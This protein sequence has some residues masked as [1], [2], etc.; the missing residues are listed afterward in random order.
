MISFKFHR[1]LFSIS[2][3]SLV[4]NYSLNA[5]NPDIEPVINSN[6]SK[7]VVETLKL[8]DY[9]SYVTQVCTDV[10]KILLKESLKLDLVGNFIV[11]GDLHG[12][13]ISFGICLTRILH[14]LKNGMSALF[15]GDYV[16]RGSNGVEVITKVFELKILYPNN[17]FILRGNHEDVRQNI[18]GGFQE[19][20]RIKF[21]ETLE[22]QNSV[23][24]VISDVWD[25]LPI[26][27]VINKEFFC[28]HGGI[29][30]VFE[31]YD[32]VGKHLF[33]D[34]LE[35]A[36]KPLQLAK[37]STL[38]IRSV[39]EMLWND[40]SLY[41]VNSF[42]KRGGDSLEIGYCLKYD[43]C[44]SAKVNYIVR[45]HQVL[46]IFPF[47]DNGKIINVFSCLYHGKCKEEDE[48]CNILIINKPT[49]ENLKNTITVEKMS[50]LAKRYSHE[51][52]NNLLILFGKDVLK[53]FL[54]ST[55]YSDCNI[56]KNINNEN[57]SSQT[58]LS[59]VA[60]FVR[61]LRDALND[62]QT[63]NP[64]E[65]NEIEQQYVENMKKTALINYQLIENAYNKNNY[66]EVNKDKNLFILFEQEKEI[67]ETPLFQ[68]LNED[69][70]IRLRIYFLIASND[71]QKRC[72]MSYPIFQNYSYQNVKAEFDKID[73]DNQLELMM[74]FI[75]SF[76]ISNVHLLSLDY[77]SLLFD[78]KTG[79]PTQVFSDFLVGYSNKKNVYS[80][81]MMWYI[82]ELSYA[83]RK[84]I[85]IDD[86]LFLKFC[87]PFFD[88]EGADL[89]ANIPFL[90]DNVFKTNLIYEYGNAL[91]N[92]HYKSDDDRKEG[93]TKAA[94]VLSILTDLKQDLF[95]YLTYN[96]AVCLLK[97]T[98]D[99]HSYKSEVVENEESLIEK[100]I[101]LWKSLIS[102]KNEGLEEIFQEDNSGTYL[103]R[104]LP[105][106][107]KI[108]IRYAMLDEYSNEYS[109]PFVF[110]LL[111]EKDS[112]GKTFMS[113]LNM[114]HK[115][116]VINN[117]AEYAFFHPLDERNRT[118]LE[119]I[120]SLLGFTTSYNDFNGDKEKEWGEN[121]IFLMGILYES[122]PKNQK[123][124]IN[125]RIVTYGNILFDQKWE[126]KDIFLKMEK[127]I[128]A[129]GLYYY[130]MALYQ[131]GYKDTALDKFQKIASNYGTDF[132]NYEQ[133]QE[134]NK[135]YS[136]RNLL[137]DFS[138]FSK[139]V[140]HKGIS[141]L[142]NAVDFKAM[143]PS[144]DTVFSSSLR[145]PTSSET[146]FNS[147]AENN[148]D[149]DNCDDGEPA[150]TNSP[151]ISETPFAFFP[152]K[153]S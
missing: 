35:K 91:Y 129:Q 141:P 39:N 57:I 71:K 49:D 144:D 108:G 93:L 2:L 127:N 51:I 19:E 102:R 30:I 107:A 1:V 119:V 132:L 149:K 69:Q 121:M 131:S 88:F 67:Y 65:Y 95:K 72:L 40:F 27:A 100:T 6:E 116:K 152:M 68:Y 44:K 63:I 140:A 128:I 103:Y 59:Q 41:P 110:P 130:G 112:D 115:M 46:P 136:F 113:I 118:I 15:L 94:Q 36:K 20:C 61:P 101:L 26:C 14:G 16:D 24:N 22:K 99:I 105:K 133:F 9:S 104:S 90:D 150:R 122:T 145:L 147:S 126:E 106:F 70:R 146:I 64:E 58:G 48:N 54:Q 82:N 42:S 77:F 153:T 138:F 151:D 85:P 11:I 143:L 139:P 4:S 117:L 29:P 56:L 34:D 81:V 84:G 13:L 31:T 60:L 74:N 17:V 86:D 97:K 120:E 142:N 89:L 79:E 87:A 33:L 10:K 98:K 25:Y 8:T 53:Q 111:I 18:A 62:L 21:N 124:E 32:E 137:P 5:V 83:K 73:H 43:F 37:D 47:G 123:E 55:V 135:I 109:T 114:D 66:E 148:S 76:G 38:F 92:K 28:V 45:A 80:L 75:N 23:Y 12:D 7:S 134:V 125:K 50:L 96:Q 52:Y 3:V 78:L